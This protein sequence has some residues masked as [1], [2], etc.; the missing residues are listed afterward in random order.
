VSAACHAPVSRRRANGSRPSRFLISSDW[1]KGEAE[2]LNISVSAA[3]VKKSFD[4][5][6][7]EEFPRRREFA[8]FLRKSG[9]TVADLLLRVELNVL[10]ERI[11]LHVVA[12]HHSAS[13]QRRALSQF[14]KAFKAKW[15]AQ[16]YCAS[17][18]DVKDCGHVQDTV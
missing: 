14:V 6:R 11:Q 1:V 16:T 18:Y 3:E 2:N 13:S 9:Q 15:E 4:R 12:G 8:A 7:G 5:I 17:Q 10:S